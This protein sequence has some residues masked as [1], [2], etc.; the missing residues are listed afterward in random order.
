MWRGRDMG[1]VRDVE[2]GIRV[3]G[4]VVKGE[5]QVV[6]PPTVLWRNRWIWEVGVG[7]QI[8][9]SAGEQFD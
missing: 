4:M 3:A 5:V 8:L 2:A 7:L 1:E 6:V 9:E